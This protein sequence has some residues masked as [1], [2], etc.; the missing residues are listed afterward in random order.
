MGICDS[1]KEKNSTTPQQNNTTTLQ[2]NNNTASPQ[3]IN[4]TTLANNEIKPEATIPQNT[5]ESPYIRFEK[6]N[7]TNQVIIPQVPSDFDRPS[8]ID[9]HVSLGSSI[10]MDD[11]MGD[12]YPRNTLASNN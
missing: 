9:R 3:V 5:P 6:N 10:N 2:Q 8:N 11:S 7:Q 4:T 1:N 12:N